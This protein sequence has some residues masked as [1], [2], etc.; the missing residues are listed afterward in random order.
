MTI[1]SLRANPKF[2]LYENEDLNLNIK[3]LYFKPE[4]N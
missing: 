2:F 3:N 1:I 4:K